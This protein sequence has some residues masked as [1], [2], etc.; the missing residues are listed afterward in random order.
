MMSANLDPASESIMT[1]AP[2]GRNSRSDWVF[3]C[4]SIPACRNSSSVRR[5]KWAAR[6]RADPLRRRSTATDLTPY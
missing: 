2:S 4:S 6:G 3:T 1:I 5:W